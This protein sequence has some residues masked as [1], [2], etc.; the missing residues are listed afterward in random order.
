MRKDPY[1]LSSISRYCSPKWSPV[2]TSLSYLHFPL[3]Q[4]VDVRLINGAN[5]FIARLA[6]CWQHNQAEWGGLGE[7]ITLPIVRKDRGTRLGQCTLEGLG[8]W[9]TLWHC[10]P[11]QPLNTHTH[12]TPQE[13]NKGLCTSNHPVAVGLETLTAQNNTINW[14]DI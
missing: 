6:W 8:H 5:C 13:L 3:P 7:A 14:N 4:I 12:N 11:K 1:P 2:S 9:E 10:A